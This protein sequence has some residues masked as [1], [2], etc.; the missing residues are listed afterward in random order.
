MKDALGHGS[1]GFGRRGAPGAPVN[2]GVH[3]MKTN[4]IGIANGAVFRTVPRPTAPADHVGDLR[5]RLRSATGDGHR[6]SLFQG[7]KNALGYTS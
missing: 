3:A 2:N 5:N 6:Q 4:G 7:I 1:E